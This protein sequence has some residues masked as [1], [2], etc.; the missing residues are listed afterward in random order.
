M[1]RLGVLSCERLH[2]HRLNRGQDFALHFLKPPITQ[3]RSAYAS[4]VAQVAFGESK[5][6]DDYRKNL[7]LSDSVLLKILVRFFNQT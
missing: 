7:A 2:G 3:A 1:K 6:V 5:L 4:R